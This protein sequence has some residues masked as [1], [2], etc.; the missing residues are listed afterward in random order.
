MTDFFH[1]LAAWAQQVADQLGGAGLALVAFFDSSF[2]TLPEVADVLV[3]VFTIREPSQWAYFAAMTTL[4]SVTGCLALFWVGRKGGDALLRRRFHERHVDRGLRW[5]Q[6][7]GA[8]VLVVPALLPPPMPF[9]IFVLLAGVSGVPVA[10]FVCAVAFA[11][12]LRYGGFALL[13]YYYGNWAV[14]VVQNNVYDVILPVAAAVVALAAAWLA[15]RRWG[16]PLLRARPSEP[17]EGWTAPA[18][19]E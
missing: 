14:Q 8:L 4:G 6:R 1:S 9:K 17:P 7:Y 10:H 15:W 12:G 5:F 13:A 18:D 16:A 11:R 2:L 3:A 19:V